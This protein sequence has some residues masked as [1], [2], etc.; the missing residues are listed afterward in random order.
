[1][2]K[3][4]VV[5]VGAGPVG[6]VASIVLAR[7]W[8]DKNIILV[9]KSTCIGGLLRSFDYGEHGCFDYGAHNFQE[10]LIE[11]LDQLFLSVIPEDQ[12]HILTESQREVAG[13]FFQGK[14]HHNTP[15]LDLRSLPEQDYQACVQDFFWNLCKNK[16]NLSRS[17]ESA[18]D[19][20]LFSYGK[21]IAENV[22]Q[23]IL[24]KYF[25]KDIS[26]LHRLPLDF[27]HL[28]R[29]AFLDEEIVEDLTR[30]DLLRKRIAF[31]E[32]RDLPL[33]RSAGKRNFY[34]VKMGMQQVINGFKRLLEKLNVK[35]ITESLISNIT[36]EKDKV[37]S[38]RVK[39]KQGIESDLS[40]EHLIWAAGVHP[41][42]VNLGLAHE[43]DFF[44]KPL[45]T[46]FVHL[47]LDK[48]L[49]A[50]DLH[51]IY[52][53]DS[54]F[55]TYRVVNYA[56]YCPQANEGP[57]YPVTLEIFLPE[58]EEYHPEAIIDRAIDELKR[59]GLVEAGTNIVFSSAERTTEGFPMPTLQNIRLGQTRRE[60]IQAKQLKNLTLLGVLSED[61]LFFHKDVIVHAFQTVK[62]LIAR[63]LK[64]PTQELETCRPIRR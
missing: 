46:V 42:T 37:T 23:P 31:T 16:E 17:L 24:T 58:Q 30:S 50:L 64:T 35:V 4:N 44:D 27:L 11:E 22:I 8:P 55:Y 63:S 1:M 29:I 52:P 60:R 6:I 33:A 49:K 45:Q 10:T 53:F 19:F 39:D 12:W 40:T 54:D 47:R 13:H 14:L 56:N 38:V 21:K 41:L 32:Q 20:C 5:I 28:N 48:K 51:Y 34:P 62:F 26:V 43:N 18:Y 9:E 59:M 3:S 57:Y 36:L 61:N 7:A 2:K 15:F 25:G